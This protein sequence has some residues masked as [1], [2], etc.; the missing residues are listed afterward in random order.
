MGGSVSD[1]PS[2]R[3]WI[4]HH[5]K[6]GSAMLFHFVQSR[7]IHMSSMAYRLLIA[8]GIWL[9][10]IAAPILLK[11]A[12]PKQPTRSSAPAAKKPRPLKRNFIMKT[13]GGRQFWGDVH[14][15]HS[16]RIQQNVVTKHF[17]LLD[18]DDHRH[19]SGSLKKCRDKLDEIRKQQKL[20]P[21]KGKAVIV[22]HGIIRSS[23]S[24][25]KMRERLKKEGYTVIGFDYPSTRVDIT[26]SAEYLRK[27]IASLEGINEI[28]FVVHSMGG[29][30][31]RCY[32]SK[33]RDKRI[34][35]MAMLGVP[36]N[37]A[38]MADTLKKNALFRM[39][40]GPAGQQL[41]SDPKGFIKKLPVPDFEFAIVAGA[42]GTLKGYNPLIPGDDDG[43]VSLKSARLQGAHDFIT[44]KCLHSFLVSHPE[45]IKATVHFLRDGRLRKKGPRHPI[46]KSAP[47]AKIPQKKS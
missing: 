47:T 26:T 19:A 9:C 45:A 22:V 4:P 23:K 34:K 13:L 43:T 27:V 31:V 40:L 32:L 41:T 3:L 25:H 35:R 7:Q 46:P 33:G 8:S 5:Q 39:F 11:A 30:L 42:R 20:P 28:H 10:L 1:S 38:R 14:A 44:V 29:L 12:P 16:W 37:G 2:L 36:N 15:F 17:R 24:F 18:G 6:K 21:M